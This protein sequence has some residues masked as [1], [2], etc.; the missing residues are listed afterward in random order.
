MELTSFAFQKTWDIDLF[1]GSISFM[2]HSSDLPGFSQFVESRTP[3]SARA[4]GFIQDFWQHAFDCIL[5]NL[6]GNVDRYACTEEEKMES[7]PGS[8]YEKHIYG[9]SYSV[10][11]SVY[12]LAHALHA[13][14]SYRLKHSGEADGEQLKVQNQQKQQLHR[15][16]RGFSFNNT[17]GDTVSLNKNGVLVAGLDIINWIV[18]SNGSFQTLK[19]GKIDYK[20]FPYEYEA[21]SINEDAIT[22]HHWFNQVQPFSLCNE[23]CHPGSS[24]K[25]KEGGPICCFDCT[26]CPE[27]MISS[28]MNMKECYKC[29]D[30][31]YPNENQ[32]FCIPKDITFLSYEEPLGISL[33][34]IVISFS[35]IT[36]LVLGI[37]MRHHNT[38]I[39]KANNRNLTYTLLISLLLCF[40]CALLFIGHPQK[41]TCI[42]RQI[43]F[44]ITFSVA[45]SC[46]LAKTITVVLAFMAT[47]PGSKMRNWIGKRLLNSLVLFCSLLQ[48]VICVVWLAI[49][50]PF[51]DADMHS[52]MKEI[53]LE[54]NEGSAVM[55]YWV[56]GYMGFLAIL[57]FIVAFFARKLPDSFNEAKFIT[58]SMLLFCG[59]WISFVPAYLSSKGK[60]MVA[61]EI[62]SILASSAGLLVCIFPPKCY[63]IVFKS[64]MNSKKHLIGRK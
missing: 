9:N 8:I 31:K 3:S 33:A 28:R 53:I 52:V 21:F 62:F 15:I 4:D 49:S 47:K 19:V 17:A 38:P 50:P 30:E 37:F 43:A 56:L 25:R 59:V 2:I 13:V 64:E 22:W 36:T 60:Y 40:L 45:V 34:S 27:G 26:R 55:F 7:L 14:S 46:V 39:V 6:T 23:Y 41:V 61:V 29:T 12:I 1:H 48:V 10:Y 57:S 11:N 24:M 35:L 32:D 51:P 20:N 5:P 42:L 18:F 63:I 54:C 44:G 58:F 16:L